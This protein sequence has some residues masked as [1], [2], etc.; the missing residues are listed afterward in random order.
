[1]ASFVPTFVDRVVGV[2]N[3]NGPHGCQSQ[4]SGQE[5]FLFFQVA[6]QLYSRG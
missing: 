1:M 4:L 5:P 6:P 2:V 3:A